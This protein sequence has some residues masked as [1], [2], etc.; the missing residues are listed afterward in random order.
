MATINAHPRPINLSALQRFLVM[1]E[2]YARFILEISQHAA[3]LNALKEKGSQF[4]WTDQ[5][6]VA[7]DALKKA[8]SEAS[9][10]QIPDI[11]GEFVLVTDASDLAISAVLNQQVDGSLTPHCLLQSFA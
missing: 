3:P 1:V 9:V 2:F 6:Q 8:L 7:F 5:H 10:L 4:T 11:S